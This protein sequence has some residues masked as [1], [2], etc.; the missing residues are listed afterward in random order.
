MKFVCGLTALSFCLAACSGDAAEDQPTESSGDR[1]AL[2]IA[3]QNADL[4][5]VEGG[6]LGTV[7]FR[8]DANG[9]TLSVEVGGLKP[10]LHGVHLHEAGICEQPDFKSAGGHWNPTGAE[11]GRDNPMGS[12]LGDLANLQVGEDGTGRAD[13][14]VRDVMIDK[15]EWVLSDRNGTALVVHAAADDYVSNPA[16]DAGARVACAVL[17]APST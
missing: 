7:S 5:S 6:S 8:Q 11:H 15:G 14:L 17:A 1:G 9:V 2:V 13:Y 10:G 4:R 16:G 3:P 12:H